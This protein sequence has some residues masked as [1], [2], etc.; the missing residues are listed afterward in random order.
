MM[1]S[2]ARAWEAWLGVSK[3]HVAQQWQAQA[4]GQ[5]TASFYQGANLLDQS[6]YLPTGCRT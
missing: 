4:I 3:V 5:V 1:G 2:W 6:L